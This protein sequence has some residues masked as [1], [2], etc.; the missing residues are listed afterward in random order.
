MESF[1]PSG[2]ARLDR[3]S[4]LFHSLNTSELI[5]AVKLDNRHAVDIGLRGG[6]G[7][8]HFRSDESLGSSSNQHLSLEPS[9]VVEGAAQLRDF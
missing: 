6:R 5:F 9:G 3:S 1:F 2:A 4:S 8:L 7:R